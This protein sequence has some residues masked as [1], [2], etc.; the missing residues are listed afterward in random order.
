MTIQR[1]GKKPNAAPSVAASTAC[2]TGISKKATA[3]TS[4]TAREKS[5]A[6]QAL[7]LSPP[8]STKM[9]SSGNAPHSELSASESPTGG[10]SCSNTPLRCPQVAVV[11][12][13]RVG[14]SSEVDQQHVRRGAVGHGVPGVAGVAGGVAGAVG[15]VGVE[16]GRPPVERLGPEAAGGVGQLHAVHAP[17]VVVVEREHLG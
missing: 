16:G 8:S 12:P 11:T 10:R 1:I 14:L 9:A 15:G 2:P 4:A 17:A 6:R 5:P 3:T 13:V 7:I